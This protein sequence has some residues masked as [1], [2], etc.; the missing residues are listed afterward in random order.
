ADTATQ[1]AINN[2][3]GQ[4]VVNEA[5]SR[6]LEVIVS[7]TR[8]HLG[9]MVNSFTKSRYI[10]IVGEDGATMENRWT[11]PKEIT[12]K[13][14]IVPQVFFD[15]GTKQRL[16]QL[17][18]GLTNV[19]A[20]VA[21]PEVVIELATIA[22]EQAGVPQ[23]Q[24]ERVLKK[25]G[26]VTNVHQEIEAMLQDPDIRP[27]VKMGDPHPVCIMFAQIAMQQLAQ[28]A[29]MMGVPFEPPQNVQEYIALHEAM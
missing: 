11:M 21:G 20:P 28:R 5:S 3:R 9:C 10:P 26:D 2:R 13:L 17:F 22:M 16:S 29:A 7:A 4:T 23:A 19:L 8:K 27:E 1:E 18:L 14:D 6:M 25:Q 15:E 24:I 12:D